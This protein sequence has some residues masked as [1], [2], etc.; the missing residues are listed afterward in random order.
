MASEII[1]KA[2]PII[3]LEGGFKFKLVVYLT[4]L[5]SLF[6]AFAMVNYGV[7]VVEPS[8]APV[9]LQVKII[10][11]SLVRS[12]EGFQ[13]PKDWRMTS[14]VDPDN[15][16]TLVSC[17]DGRY[18]ITARENRPPQAFDTQTGQMIDSDQFYR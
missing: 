9:P 8:I 3:H 14:G 6:G 13:C 18:I 17:T 10:P 1:K 2:K 5:L 15:K 16:L 11:R 7:N 4:G 12:P